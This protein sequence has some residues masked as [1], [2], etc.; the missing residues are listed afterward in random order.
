MLHIYLLSTSGGRNWAYFRSTTSG[1]RDT[2]Q[3]SKLL[4][5]GMKLGHWPKFQALH[6]YCL[7]TL[8]GEKWAYF[9]STGRGFWDILD[10]FSKLP[11][12]G[13]KLG[14]W[15]KCQILH[16]YHLSTPRGS[17]SSLF[18]LYRQRFSGYRLIFKIAI[19]GHETWPLAKMPDVAHMPSFYPRGSKLSLFSLYGH[20][21]R[22][23]G[24]FSKLPY[25]GMKL[26]HWPISARN[27]IYS[28]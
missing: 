18:S 9:H 22:D 28:S 1:F 3:F 2:G 8:G 10:W 11:Y 16:I 13:M 15:A 4:Y 23:M 19:F 14:H 7:S 12:L 25:L 24:R 27:C 6:I 20:G 5:F 17:K 21:F 26:C